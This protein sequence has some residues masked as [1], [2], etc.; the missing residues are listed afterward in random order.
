M[1]QKSNTL[2]I[3]SFS[4]VLLLQICLLPFTQ[5]KRLI[6]FKNIVLQTNLILVDTRNLFDRQCDITPH[7][8]S[9]IFLNNQFISKYSLS[10]IKPYKMPASKIFSKELF[11]NPLMNQSEILFKAFT[12]GYT[13]S[14][15]KIVDSEAPV[16][17][18]MQLESVPDF[19]LQF[20]IY[21]SVI[22]RE[23][24]SLYTLAD[25]LGIEKRKLNPEET[26]SAVQKKYDDLLQYCR[27]VKSYIIGTKNICIFIS[28]VSPQHP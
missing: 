17:F 23:H 15:P 19:V 16:N 10:Q 5:T 2:S 14:S 27:F 24:F 13:T 1:T 9:L 22:I 8:D 26:K 25:L 12:C 21:H 7:G 18:K 11:T 4:C 28:D 20:Q 3:I 6:Q